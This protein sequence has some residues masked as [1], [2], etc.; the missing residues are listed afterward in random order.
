MEIGIL[1]KRYQSIQVYQSAT[2]QWLRVAENAIKQ[3][4]NFI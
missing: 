2:I 1:Q 4:K 3:K